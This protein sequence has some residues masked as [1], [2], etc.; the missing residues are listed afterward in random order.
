MASRRCCRKTMMVGTSFG[1]YVVTCLVYVIFCCV[2][3]S[4]LA[5]VLSPYLTPWVAYPPGV[6]LCALCLVCFSMP[7]WSDPGYLPVSKERRLVDEGE[8]TEVEDMSEG[9]WVY[10]HFDGVYF[11]AQICQSCQ[12]VRP[13]GTSHCGTCGHCIVNFDHHCPWVGTDVGLRNHLYFIIATGSIALYCGWTLIL[14]VSCM[15]LYVTGKS[16]TFL[17]LMACLLTVM[18][19]FFGFG[20]GLCMGIGHCGFMCADTNTRASKRKRDT[21]TQLVQAAYA[22]QASMILDPSRPVIESLTSDEFTTLAT[23]ILQRNARCE[24]RRGWRRIILGKDMP[25]LLDMPPLEAEKV[26][27]LWTVALAKSQV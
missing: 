20:F 13:P 1:C 25:Q 6:I 9:E 8:T 7:A 27:W 4:L 17:L 15:F 18:A 19:S 16:D 2:S 10:Y 21:P 22:M 5:P 12:L 23:P 24:K 3:T 26:A 14:G 11:E